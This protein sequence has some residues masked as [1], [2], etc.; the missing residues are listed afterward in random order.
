MKLS[1]VSSS[2]LRGAEH[3]TLV[4]THFQSNVAVWRDVYEQDGVEGAIYRKRLDTVLRWIDGLAIPR[5]EKVLEI[6]CGAGRCTVAMA[7]RG[8]VVHAL[9]S[10][11]GMVK[12]TQERTTQAG[13]SSSVSIGLGDAHHLAF[14]DRSFALV[15]AVG[16][17][18]YLH[19][20]QKAL[21]E[22][23]RVLRPGGFLLVTS[24]NRWRLNN[25]LDPWNCPLLQPAKKAIGAI[26]RL[27]R[28]ARPG[29]AVPPL[30]LG[31]LREL[32]KWLSPVGLFKIKATS[33]GFPSITFRG[34]AILREQIS[35]RLNNR[36]QE[37]ADRNVPWVRSSGMDYIVLA[38][39]E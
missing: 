26:V 36:L 34:R 31:S 28:K 37:L 20:P 25:V 27:F 12:S 3:Q 38:R 10:V 29:D 21:G 18:P 24:G 33:V 23:A 9:D 2:I 1:A 4:D 13:V 19:F 14:S 8:Y 7:Q 30:R 5:G 32:E 15:L 35:M 11:P 16:V 39:K 6:G 17:I 22:M